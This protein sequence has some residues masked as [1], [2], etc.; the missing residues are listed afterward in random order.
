MD[1]GKFDL[2]YTPLVG[3]IPFRGNR[4]PINL[5]ILSPSKIRVRK[6]KFH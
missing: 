2:P 6:G 1:K 5:S 4:V 3:L